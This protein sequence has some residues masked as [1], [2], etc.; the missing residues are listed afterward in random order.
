MTSEIDTGDTVGGPRSV[1]G[2]LDYSENVDL[3]YLSQFLETANHIRRRV[4]VA[5]AGM[6][7]LANVDIIL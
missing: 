1:S 7:N 4:K 5:N 6:S 3:L 2:E